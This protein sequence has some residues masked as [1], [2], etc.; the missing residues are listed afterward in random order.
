[1][2]PER[3]GSFSALLLVLL[4]AVMVLAVASPASAL[5]CG[6][7]FVEDT[8]EE[9][10]RSLELDNQTAMVV[11]VK[12]T[13]TVEGDTR[14]Y[15]RFVSSFVDRNYVDHSGDTNDSR[16]GLDEG[17]IGRYSVN[18]LTGQ[19]AWNG[20]ETLS[21]DEQACALLAG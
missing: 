15:F 4:A 6:E 9:S 19:E 3:T 12:R 21:P 10:T 20:R 17:F 5:E 11:H 8:Y 13:Y 2:R 14:P 18:Y 7:T 1:M 16:A